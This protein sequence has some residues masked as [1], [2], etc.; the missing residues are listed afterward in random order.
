MEEFLSISILQLTV[1]EWLIDSEFYSDFFRWKNKEWIASQTLHYSLRFMW[2]NIAD[3]WCVIVK[4]ELEATTNIGSLYLSLKTWTLNKVKYHCPQIKSTIM[5]NNLMVDIGDGLQIFSSNYVNCKL[6]QWYQ[7]KMNILIVSIR[8]LAKSVPKLGDFALKYCLAALICTW[9]TFS[10]KQMKS[11][12]QNQMG[13][14][15]TG[16]C[17]WLVITN[18]DTGTGEIISAPTSL[19]R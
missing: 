6:T 11:K 12:W 3:V 7:T 8:W 13:K 14:W 10:L 1:Q 4:Q 9:S 5:I 19:K 18:I 16:P 15:N 17:L 2:Q